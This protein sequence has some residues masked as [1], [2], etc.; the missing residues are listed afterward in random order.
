MRVSFILLLLLA[1]SCGTLAV[2]LPLGDINVV[3]LT[4]DHSWVAG[5]G[6]HESLDVDYGDVLSFYERLSSA[7]SKSVFLV[8]N[9]D[10]IDGTGL[11][12][13]PPV[14][15]EPILLKMPWDAITV[16]NHDIYKNETVLHM[17]RSGGLVEQ[18]GER[19]LT[20]NI[21]YAETGK[22]IG[23]RY[24]YLRRKNTTILAFG[25]MYNLNGVGSPLTRVQR[26]QDVVRE[27][28]FRDVLRAGDYDA[29]LVLAHMS[30]KNPSIKVILSA[31][32]NE[33]SSTMPV[34]F[35]NGHTHH[36]RV[37]VL[38]SW[39]TAV[40]AGCY[41]QTVGFVSFPTKQT[42]A[43]I[44][45]VTAPKLIKHEFI[46]A[47]RHELESRLGVPKLKTEN[48]QALTD[49][50]H[51]TQQDMGLSQVVGCSPHT[52]Y[53][54]RTLYEDDS[55]FGL[56]ARKVIATQF[57]PN[58]TKRVVLQGTSS[59]FR[60]DLFRGNVTLDDLMVVSPFNDSMYLIASNVPTATIVELNDTMNQQRTPFFLGLPEFFVI[61]N[62]TA[63][64]SHDL[65]TLEYEVP[66]IKN[67]LEAISGGQL[68]TKPVDAFATSL[69][70]AYFRQVWPKCP[71][72]SGSTNDQTKTTAEGDITNVVDKKLSVNTQAP[73]GKGAMFMAITSA[74][75]ACILLGRFMLRRLPSRRRPEHSSRLNA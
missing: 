65:Y 58:D 18:L 10:W 66:F 16:G 8:H 20:S 71:S 5:H 35:I 7:T 40:E 63:H 56:W 53:E 13:Y 24:K 1:A 33:T 61:G 52:Y 22:P 75:S 62:L 36:R 38:D 73:P 21:V 23:H 46:E 37:R 4:D 60:Y 47:K 3:V 59:S 54:H 26:V 41:L 68:E 29:I 69:W 43:S 6:A 44:E 72:Q 67:A 70:L 39:S 15:L 55:L 19:Y 50:I 49:F 17:T 12:T 9:G 34:Q 25:F 31:I 74:V 42:V 48:G 14:H 64:E 2:N 45:H 30:V 32:R 27:R 28:W 11:S 51:K 57:L